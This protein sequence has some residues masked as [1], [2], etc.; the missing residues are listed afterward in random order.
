MQIAESGTDNPPIST[1]IARIARIAGISKGV[2]RSAP[3]DP[4]SGAYVPEDL[5][6]LTARFRRV[7]RAAERVGQR[8]EDRR[9]ERRTKVDDGQVQALL[10]E[11]RRLRGGPGHVVPLEPHVGGQGDL[12]RV[13]SH[14][15]AVLVEHVALAGEVLGGPAHEVPV[16]GV[17]RGGAQGAPLAAAADDDR[18]GGGP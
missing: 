8:G 13:P 5:L 6:R 11:G 12:L 16:L 18:R 7:T 4:D 3:G 10:P 15:R 1:W 9:A 2:P 14:V 17:H